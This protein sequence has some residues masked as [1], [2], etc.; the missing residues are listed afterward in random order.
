MCVYQ[1]SYTALAGRNQAHMTGPQEIL[2]PGTESS[3]HEGHIVSLA[4]ARKARSQW[5]LC[6]CALTSAHGAT[7][8]SAVVHVEAVGRY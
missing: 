1:Q 3:R 7:A 8:A 2:Q 6:T 5:D 4:Q